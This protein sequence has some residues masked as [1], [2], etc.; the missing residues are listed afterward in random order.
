M[1]RIL[2][3][4]GTRLKEKSTRTALVGTIL[5]IIGVSL[6]P[7][8]SEAIIAGIAAVVAVIVSFLPEK[9]PDE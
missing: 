4:I 1:S 9:N 6:S 3:Y 7:E 5:A 2:K 8:Q